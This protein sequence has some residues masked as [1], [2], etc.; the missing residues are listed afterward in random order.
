MTLFR[1]CN[2]NLTH[3]LIKVASNLQKHTKIETRS[4]KDITSPMAY[5][6][7]AS[8]KPTSSTQSSKVIKHVNIG[9]GFAP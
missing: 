9:I 3:L 1:K 7:L 2:S 8:Y 5:S 4:N 6:M